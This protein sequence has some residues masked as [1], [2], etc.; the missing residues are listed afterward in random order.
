MFAHKHREN[1]PA[2]NDSHAI[3]SCPLQSWKAK[4]FIVLIKMQK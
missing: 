3:A 4:W 1:I 2:E